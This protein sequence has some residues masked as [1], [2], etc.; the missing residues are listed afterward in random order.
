MS[1]DLATVPSG[2]RSGLRRGR[3][4]AFAALAA[5]ACLLAVGAA[6]WWPQA[7]EPRV[8]AGLWRG[9]ADHPAAGRV[10]PIE[11]RLAPG[12]ESA[13]RWGADLHCRGVLSPGGHELSF[14]LDRV[15]GKEC[16]PGVV[17]LVPT[18]DPNQMDIKV[19]RSGDSTVTYTGRI[20]R[21][22]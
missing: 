15:N 8:V 13:M 22:S 11:V 14:A 20:A 6:L 4:L 2:R 7:S 5:L 10:F 1:D 21:P 19:Q 18:E 9:T 3:V 12:G 17:T 16:Y